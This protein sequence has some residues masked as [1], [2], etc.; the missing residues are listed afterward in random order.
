M[1][2]QSALAAQRRNKSVKRLMNALLLSAAFVAAYGGFAAMSCEA[3][4]S[5]DACIG[6]GGDCLDI[7]GLIDGAAAK[8]GGMVVVPAGLHET[9]PLQLKSNVELHFEDGAEL[10]F[11]DDINAYLPPVE[12]ARGG[13]ECLS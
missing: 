9:G 11:T 1:N 6:G 7:Q 3:K 13:V 5:P 2:A 4:G 10:L 8:G 12:T